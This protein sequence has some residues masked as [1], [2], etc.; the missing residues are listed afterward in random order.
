VPTWRTILAVVQ[1]LKVR[2]RMPAGLRP[3]VALFLSLLTSTNAS[4]VRVYR[5]MAGVLEALVG[6]VVLWLTVTGAY[7]K[8]VDT[9]VPGL[10]K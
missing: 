3:Y 2:M 7:E 6:A 4:P 1:V 5:E 10:R 9:G 8:G